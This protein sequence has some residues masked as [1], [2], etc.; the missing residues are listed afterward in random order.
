MH[1]RLPNIAGYRACPPPTGPGVCASSCQ[2]GRLDHCRRSGKYSLFLSF[3]LK[4]MRLAQLTTAI[5]VNIIHPIKW[6][7]FILTNRIFTLIGSK[8]SQK[9]SR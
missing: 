7:D 5:H 2:Q 9:N 8:L 4:K 1:L 3:F 6:Q